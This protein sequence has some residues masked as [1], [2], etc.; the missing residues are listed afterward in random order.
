[1]VEQEDEKKYQLFLQE[2][3]RSFGDIEITTLSE[4]VKNISLSPSVRSGD[5]NELDTSLKYYEV[6]LRDID[7]MGVVTIEYCKNKKLG[8]G[9]RYLI[10]KYALK[11]NDLLLPYRASRHI[12]VARVGSHYPASIVTNASIIIN[13]TF[14]LYV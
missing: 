4:L 10:H 13:N 8:P 1:M 14:R 9:N 3:K 5:V 2:L 11:E 7:D 6:G 12:K